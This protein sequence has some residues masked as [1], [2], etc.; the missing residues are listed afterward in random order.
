MIL[1]HM[2]LPLRH[3]R[4][5]LAISERHVSIYPDTPSDGQRTLL[6]GS[7]VRL[8]C[9]E[10]GSSVLTVYPVHLPL[11]LRPLRESHSELPARTARY[12]ASFYLNSVTYQYQNSRMD[13][14]N[15]LP[16]NAFYV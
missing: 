2:R 11:C 5:V 12:L 10:V 6:T 1:S 8:I 16:F 3:S 15:S 14:A 4:K 9:F 13:L 7:V